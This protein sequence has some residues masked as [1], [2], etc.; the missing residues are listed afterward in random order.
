MKKLNTIIVLLISVLLYACEQKTITEK[1]INIIPKPA[2]VQTGTGFF[3]L[4]KKTSIYLGEFAVLEKQF[5]QEIDGETGLRLSVS[6]KAT[7]GIQL[8]KIDGLA[9]EE[10]QLKVHKNAVEIKATSSAG[11]YYAL[12]TLKQLIDKKNKNGGSFLIPSVEI[13]DKPA[14]AW[15]G[16]MLDV[17]RHFFGI[18]DIKKVLDFMAEL[19]LN[20]FHWH[21][22]DDQGWRIE[23]KKYPKLT[24]IGAWRVDYNVTDEN[25]SNWWGR[26]VQ[27]PNEKATYGGFYTQEQIKEIVA[28]AKERHIEILPEVDVP[29]HSQEILA[30]YPEVSCEPHRKFYVATG[31]VYKD[32][33]LCPSNPDTYKFLTDVLGE[34]MDL[35]PL[36]YIHIGGDECNKS[37]W[38]NH[39]QCQQFIRKKGLKNEHELQSYF[40][41]E[42][43]KIVNAKGKNM[44]GWNEILE[45]GLAP[46]ATVMSWQGEKGGILA[47]K[48]G[49]DVIM[50]PMEYVYL[51]LKQ[52]Q[53]GSE[54]NLGYS[55]AL[56][57][58]CYNYSVIPK[59]FTEEQASKIL[60]LQGN[61]WTES[62]SDWDKLTYMTFPR[63]FAVA[64]NG[65]TAE[66]EQDFDNF[67][68]RLR[69]QL[70]KLDAKG[71]RYAKSV[72][73]P[74]IHHK[75][76]R[77]S[78]EI[79]L[80]SELTAPEIR[81]TLN[82]NEPTKDS[83]LYTKPFTITETKTIRAAIFKNGIRLGDVV[84]ASYT[85][86]KAA[87]AKV[88]YN[89]RYTPKDAA[90][91]ELALT[92][93]NYG[94]LLAPDDK[95][96][97]GFS[98]DFDVTIQLAQPTDI[99]KVQLTSLR[100]TIGGT[101]PV[102]RVEVYGAG[103][104]GKF[105]KIG[106]SGFQDECL[107]Q[108]RNKIVTTVECPAKAISK[109]RV[110]AELLNPIPKGH[111]K[112]GSKSH[113]MVDEIVV[114]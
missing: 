94:Q 86:H 71:V 15:R 52:G 89:H 80:A 41:K 98:D 95:N 54:P 84:E 64:E 105:S 57:S 5:L 9:Q 63:L 77:K 2:S 51:D 53:S 7:S 93:L 90:Q 12:Q 114:L 13:S 81:Y 74:W 4:D 102:K 28:Y 30:A 97:Q 106:D 59:D 107:I 88:V 33:A 8:H 108:G 100:K 91:K 70:K 48:A 32:N 101:Y 31:G 47:A 27:K 76:N 16:Y 42:V 38:H 46:N 25:I 24:E 78:I 104:D 75:G 19:K 10:Y 87:G 50:T 45:G 11:A 3:K 35:F 103:K 67:I 40:I 99:Q 68:E 20:R 83:P 66:S 60:G 58:A 18:D 111:H 82:G 56:L 69:V 43:E 39:K 96:W 73:N 22:T 34:V 44:I 79:T 65:W 14:F 6:E 36:N 113:L 92:D 109:I 62:I 17:S 72:F 37:G 29:G 61:L 112:A 55:E 21:L 110:K 26:P 85:I 23:I 49:H 1:E